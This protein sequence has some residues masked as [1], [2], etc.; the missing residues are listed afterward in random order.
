MEITNV[1][2]KEKSIA[3]VTVVVSP[4]EFDEAVNTVY[5][6]NRNSIMVPG[7]RKGK[8]PR[9]IIE[10]MYGEVTFYYDA[11]DALFGDAYEAALKE[12]DLTAVDQPKIDIKAI[13]KDGVTY[14]CEVQLEPEVTLG[15][16]KGLEIE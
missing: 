10:R 5:K 16:Y 12:N 15:Q 14:E 1:E 9:K 13:G 7:F 6:K 8:A 3:A 11:A 4:A 2:K